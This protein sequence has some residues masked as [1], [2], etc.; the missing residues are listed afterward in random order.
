VV[1]AVSRRAL[2]RY[3]P[4]LGHVVPTVVIGYGWVL[5][6]NGVAGWTELTIGFAMSVVGTCIAY[7]FGQRLALRSTGDGGDRAPS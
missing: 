7:V 4:L 3:L 2:A 5:P 6:R 1:A